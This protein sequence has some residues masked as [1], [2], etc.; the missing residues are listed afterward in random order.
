MPNITHI[1]TLERFKYT[2]KIVTPDVSDHSSQEM[3]YTPWEQTLNNLVDV[4]GDIPDLPDS[5]MATTVLNLQ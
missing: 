3:G 4:L 2:V 5:K 1:V